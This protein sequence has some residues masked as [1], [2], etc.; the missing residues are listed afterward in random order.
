MN[1]N[2][3]SDVMNQLA[4]LLGVMLLAGC[5]RSPDS[6]QP[7]AELRVLCG[8]SMATP[9]QEAARLFQERRAA[10]VSLDLGGSETLLPKILAGTPADVFLCHDP[11]EQKLKEA[12]KWSG[13]ARLGVLQPVLLVRPGNPHRIHSLNDLTNANLKIGI[14]DPRY[15]TCGEMFVQRLEQLNISQQV[16]KQVV[17][18]A[19]SHAEIANGLILGPLDVAVVWNFVAQLYPGKVELVPT[20]DAYPEINVTVVG[21]QSSANPNLRDVFL[22][23][24]RTDEIKTLFAKHGYGAVKPASQPL[25]SR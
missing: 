9:A 24:C 19:R 21:L 18:Q 25:S 2:H 15:S 22:E 1:N 12:K 5:S 10:R 7:T 8:S 16:M 6:T 17:L 14:G 13:S 11:F 20:K 3:Y 4:S 23:F